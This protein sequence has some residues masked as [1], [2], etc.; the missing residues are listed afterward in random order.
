MLLV[1]MLQFSSKEYISPCPNKVPIAN[2]FADASIATQ[3]I[4][5]S[6]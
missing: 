2:T 6:Y 3:L 1:V 5:D 4:L